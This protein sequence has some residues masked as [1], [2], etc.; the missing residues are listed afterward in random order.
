MVLTYSAGELHALR[1]S[2]GP[3]PRRTRKTLFKQQIW[4][5]KRSVSCS[6]RKPPPPVQRPLRVGILNVR[7]LG[8]KSSSVQELIASSEFDVFCAVE[9]WHE[10]SNSPS[11]ILSTPD[12]YLCV[13]QPRPLG[14]DESRPHGGICMFHHKTLRSTKHELGNFTP[15]T[16][17]HLSILVTSGCQ[18]LLVAGLYRPGSQ[19]T[20]PTFFSEFSEFLSHLSVLSYPVYLL[21]DLNIHL[22]N[23]DLSDTTTITHLLDSFSFVQH[24]SVPTHNRGHTLDVVITPTGALIQNLSISTPASPITL[25]SASASTNKQFHRLVML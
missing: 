15:S 11:V 1:S 23:A 12:D 16:F 2:A 24:I 7:S 8:N 13:D 9:T 4:R 14:P 20:T 25:S 22:D 5:P 18:R 17:E 10:A 3:I 19:R 21:G 6:Q